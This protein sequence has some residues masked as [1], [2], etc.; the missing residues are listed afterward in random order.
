MS[1]KNIIQK[2]KH[3]TSTLSTKSVLK[4]M[5][6]AFKLLLS[7]NTELQKKRKRNTTPKI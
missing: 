6:V 7:Q 3:T 5:P 2:K 1:H 4:L